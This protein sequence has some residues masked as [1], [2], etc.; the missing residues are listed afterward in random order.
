MAKRLKGLATSRASAH[1]AV[2]HRRGDCSLLPVGGSL[3]SDHEGDLPS[4]NLEIFLKPLCMLARRICVE[5]AAPKA[6]RLRFP[7]RLRAMK[8]HTFIFRS[9][10]ISL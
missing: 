4:V 8:L 7:H 10:S 9:I 1:F 5:F 3:S 2:S 6:R